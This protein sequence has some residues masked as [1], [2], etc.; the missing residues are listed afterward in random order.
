[1]TSS[2][3]IASCQRDEGQ[4]LRRATSSDALHCALAGLGCIFTTQRG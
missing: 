1:L 2:G 4:P 3:A